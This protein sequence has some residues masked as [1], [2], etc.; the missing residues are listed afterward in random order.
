MKIICTQENLQKNLSYLERVVV[1]QTSLPIL[2]N[3]LF[4][5]EGGQIKLSATNLEIGITTFVGGKVLEK[6]TVALPAKII[7]NFINN[8]PTGEVIEITTEDQK[9]FL[10]SGGYDLK[11]FSADGK[12]FPLIPRGSFDQGI[13]LSAQDFKKSLQSLL[14]AASTNVIRPELTGVYFL[15]EGEVLKLVAT[16]SFRL[17]EEQVRVI[18]EQSTPAAV[19][20]PTDT[21]QE[22]LRVVGNDYDE[23]T[24]VI[25]DNQ[26]FF[27]I[28]GTE[29]TSRL[30]N[31]KFPDYQQ[32][33][34]SNFSDRV[35]FKKSDLSRSLK[36]AA[37]LSSYTS[38]EI[39][40][41]CDKTK[42]EFSVVSRSHD[43]GEN[44]NR[45]NFENQEG[46]KNI[47][48][49]FQA[50]FLQDYL[51]NSTGEEI[52]LAYNTE[53]TPVLLSSTEDASLISIIMPIRK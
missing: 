48:L 19:I 28:G 31:G 43:V 32:I 47:T 38:G 16:D 37:S 15:F 12:E 46:E 33:I 1:R 3:I 40:L 53:H 21:L 51:N 26:I 22:V 18:Y 39:A 13:K 41:I 29:I 50:R 10:K 36:I 52:G 27:H 20:V 5:T 49:I 9:V 23:I 6:G 42:N 2:G 4:E 8:L 7:T 44:I 45:F 11:V 17:V 14:Y 30:I 35:I 24:F 25:Q 34:P